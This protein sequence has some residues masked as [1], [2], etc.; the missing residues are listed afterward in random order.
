VTQEISEAAVCMINQ[1]QP[2]LSPAKII[3]VR[4][5]Y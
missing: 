4:L 3:K 1:G 2:T 5:P